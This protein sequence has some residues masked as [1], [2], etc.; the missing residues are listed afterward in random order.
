[1]KQAAYRHFGRVAAFALACGTALPATAAAWFEARSDHFVIYAPGSEAVVRDYATRLERFDKGMRVMRGLADRPSDRANPL[2]VYVLPTPAAVE[3]LCRGNGKR[4]D[5][6]CR[7]VAGFYE[8]R[9]S[10]SVAF[11]PRRSG[12]GGKFDLNEQ[13]VLFHEYAH[14]FMY[15]NYTAAYPAWFSEGFAE[16]NGTARFERDG[17]IGFGIPALHRGY[18]LMTGKPLPLMAMLAADNRKLDDMQR[19]ALYGRGWLL[20]HY[21]TFSPA[22]VGQLSRYLNALNAGKPSLEAAAAAFGDLKMLDRDVDRYLQQTS[23]SYLPIAKDRVP[24]GAITV[25]ALSTGEA[26]MMPVRV[27]SERGVDAAMAVQVAGEARTIAAAHPQDPG[28]QTWLA[29]A[30]YDAGRDDLAEAA[31]DRAI[32]ADPGRREALLYKGRVR[33]RRAALARNTDPTVWREARSWF[34]KANRL[35]PDDAEPLML[36]YDSFGQAGLRPSDNAVIGLKE[37]FALAP[38]DGGLRYRVA[39][40]YLREGKP[41]DARRVLAPL[42]YDPHRGPDSDAAR[43]IA[44]IDAGDLS[45]PQAPKDGAMA[46]PD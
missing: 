20:T 33:M 10:G 43:L 42:A 23:M 21:L 36:F 41:A 24:I 6:S 39:L 46:R 28:V 35:E 37:A 12:D 9:A 19:D 27:R 3:Q 40:E 1:M 29:E 2:A 14:H 17:G 4:S 8:P 16:F 13:T 38:Q 15:A 31:A 45:V 18:G 25:R 30:E 32:A 34:V 26:A 22:R 11:T 5:L 44:R 7:N